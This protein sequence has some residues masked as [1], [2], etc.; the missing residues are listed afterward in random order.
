[1]RKRF[2]ILLVF[3]VAVSA[4]IAGCSGGQSPSEKNGEVT[5]K[6]FHR[7]PK[8][9]EKSFFDNA[10]KE[11]EKQNPKIH[12]QTEAV[13][14]DSYKEKIRVML[15]TNNP[16]DIYF[17]WS[18]EFADK[19]VRGNKALD[20]TP[21]YKED[22]KWSS[23]LVQ[24]QISP[25]T[26]NGKQYGVPWTM[27]GKTFFYNK[28]IFKKLNIQPPRTWEELISVSKVLKKHHYTPIAFGSKAP[29]A[30]SHYIG[31]L[32]QRLVDE[33][34]REKDYNRAT[35]EF[36]DPGYTEALEKFK[37]LVPYF[38]DHPNSID[39]EYA[40]QLF[41]AGKAAIIYAETAEIKLV[42]PGIKF[43]LGFFD[44]PSIPGEKGSKDFLTGAPEGFMISAKT[45]HPKEAM[46][47]LEFLTSKPMGEK[48][49]KDV[50]KYSA[51]KE[52][53]N[54]TNATPE[55]IEAVNKILDAKE[56]VPWF[57]TDVD[58]EIVDAYLNG[59]QMMLNGQKSPKGI[60]KDV[61]KAAASLRESSQ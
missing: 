55:Q 6:F 32:N 21:Y 44:F 1:M 29:W 12:I 45:K 61:R 28:N 60:M 10:V 41:T 38:N 33:K 37:E 20:L 2:G 47:F 46:K 56:M 36:K 15:G 43:K 4:L 51:V 19:F 5:L 18:D 23:Q 48:L 8:D 13:L 53:T 17:S 34:T 27:D 9:P 7:W 22:A 25:F 39:H 52:T 16:S 35:G 14:N 30:I 40:R 3:L 24:S 58:I 50:G 11:F 49:V 57:D 54:R 42:E 26:F 31:T 59:V